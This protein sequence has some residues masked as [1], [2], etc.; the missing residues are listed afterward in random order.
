L[1]QSPRNNLTDFGLAEAGFL[2]RM[3]CHSRNTLSGSADRTAP[4]FASGSNLLIRTALLG[5]FPSQQPALFMTPGTAFWTL[6][7]TAT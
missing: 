4:M 6:V 7:G 2:S 5:R 1:A 3:G